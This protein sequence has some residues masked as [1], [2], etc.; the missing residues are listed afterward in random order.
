V[1]DQELNPRPHT[2]RPAALAIKTWKYTGR[3]EGGGVGKYLEV[4]G[5][6]VVVC[7][8][9]EV[10]GVALPAQ[11]GGTGLHVVGL[12]DLHLAPRA[13]VDC[14]TTNSRA[15]HRCFV[16]PHPMPGFP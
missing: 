4:L 7:E 9:V 12:D 3:G 1:K 10:G 8:Q 5:K 13:G 6:L 16:F 15:T 14:T 2:P 11:A